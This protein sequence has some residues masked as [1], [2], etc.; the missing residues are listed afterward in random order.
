MCNSVYVHW[1]FCPKFFSCF[2]ELIY[3]S[4][5]KYIVLSMSQRWFTLSNSM[6]H[7]PGGFTFGRG[8]MPFAAPQCQSSCRGVISQP[9]LPVN[10]FPFLTAILAAL[11][12]TSSLLQ[13]YFCA[14]AGGLFRAL[15]KPLPAVQ[16]HHQFS[17]QPQFL[18]ILLT[19]SSLSPTIC[20]L[21]CCFFVC[22]S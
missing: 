18:H 16:F 7:M 6:I 1:K 9:I 22:F 3:H 12:I 8:I 15:H 2:K 19:F 21:F 17:I 14:W 11:E 5:E 10:S 4:W 13:F 20:F